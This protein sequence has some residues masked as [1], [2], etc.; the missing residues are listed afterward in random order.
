[1][2]TGLSLTFQ[3]KPE[4]AFLRLRAL[5]EE[6]STPIGQASDYTGKGREGRSYRLPA[7]GSYVLSLRKE[8][9]DSY[10]ILIHA[11]D[12]R[13]QTAVV[14]D[15]SARAGAA[16]SAVAVREGVVLRGEP[17]TARVTVDGVDRGMVRD[18]TGGIAGRKILTLTP[19]LRRVEISAPGLGSRVF[20]V[21]V[22]PAAAKERETLRFQLP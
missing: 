20:E 21:Q 10:D 4:D 17:E 13:G 18:F 6:R 15:L 5:D 16:Q 14:A 2:R 8:G 22:S 19:G 12:G 11:E 1:M 7:A 3:V 9:L